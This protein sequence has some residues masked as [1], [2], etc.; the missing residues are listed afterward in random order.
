MNDKNYFRIICPTFPLFRLDRIMTDLAIRSAS[1]R[2][3]YFPTLPPRSPCPQTPVLS[4]STTLRRSSS[5][6]IEPTV[7]CNNLKP[8]EPLPLRRSSLFT[9]DN[10][11]F[12]ENLQR[13]SSSNVPHK[14]LYC[15]HVLSELSCQ[16]LLS[17]D[18][19]DCIV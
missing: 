3:S 8:H 10:R 19:N 16:T 5:K 6:L 17:Q 14:D 9:M 2:N 13:G 15:R 7:Y 18:S 11:L 12:Q 1:R 4:G